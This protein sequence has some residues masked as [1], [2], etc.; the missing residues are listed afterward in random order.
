MNIFT[1]VRTIAYA[2]TARDKKTKYTWAL[3]GLLGISMFIG[4]RVLAAPSCSIVAGVI[5]QSITNTE[6]A[7]DGCSYTTQVLY[8]RGNDSHLY[9]TESECF[10][11]T[12]D[13]N[14]ATSAEVSCPDGYNRVTQFIGGSEYRAVCTIT[15]NIRDGAYCEVGTYN[16]DTKNCEVQ[17]CIC[18]DPLESYSEV[19]S[20]CVCA[21]DLVPASVTGSCDRDPI[22]YCETSDTYI[23][24]EALCTVNDCSSEVYATLNPDQ[25]GSGGGDPDVYCDTSVVDEYGIPSGQ[26][27]IDGEPVDGADV[28]NGN[29][30]LGYCT[31][32]YYTQPST[33]RT[34]CGTY[35]NTYDNGTTVES[36][37]DQTGV[38][39]TTTTSSA[40][41]PD[42]G[43]VVTS[44]T[45]T[46]YPDGSSTTSTMVGDSPPSVT[47]E[48]GAL[49]TVAGSG[50]PECK[51]NIYVVQ[52]GV[53]VCQSL[54]GDTA[55]ENTG[56]VGTASGG[57]TCEVAPVCAGDEIQ[58]AILY[59]QWETR[60][61]DG[62]EENVSSAGLLDEAGLNYTE[63]DIIRV[64]KDL[65]D[66]VFDATGFLPSAETCPTGIDIAVLGNNFTFSF[67][68]FCM[69]AEMLGY[70]LLALSYYIAYRNL[71]GSF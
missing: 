7:N 67:E 39:T 9:R 50:D 30:N 11:K 63:G 44:T 54:K 26:C 61:N 51:E 57:T 3:V 2:F 23:A 52:N 4:E 21:S 32:D 27:F 60:C 16:F 25:C 53:L 19:Q 15:E 33:G 5:K 70:L 13:A 55:G 64:E 10:S 47:T 38:N 69:V 40:V 62:T 20:Q 65:G 18:D 35:T 48:T 31:G 58:C 1:L 24:M 17:E 66:V 22:K 41:M 43:E 45:V 49:T 42:G 8:R 12:Y 37:T 46:T 34:A 36:S 6:G 71:L 28:D 68:G 56:P 14:T 29:N 59:Q